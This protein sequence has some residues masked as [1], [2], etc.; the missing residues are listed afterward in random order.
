M[1]EASGPKNVQ[2]SLRVTT[3]YLACFDI[4]SK[5]IWIQ[6]KRHMKLFIT[7]RINISTL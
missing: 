1:G 4:I 7:S 5:E 3:R 6:K 2:R